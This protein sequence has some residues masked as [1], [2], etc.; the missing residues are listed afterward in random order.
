MLENYKKHY[1]E[2]LK[3]KSVVMTPYFNSSNLK[4]QM[5][6]YIDLLL[7]LLMENDKFYLY[8]SEELLVQIAKLKMYYNDMIVLKN[9][10]ILRL[11]ALKE[12][13]KEKRIP[14]HN[15]IAL[16]EEINSLSVILEMF[17]YREAGINIEVQNY[18][19]VLKSKDLSDYDYS[20]LNKRL[21]KLLFISKGIINENNLFDD[22]K[23]NVAFLE[24]ECEI[25]A[26]KHKEEAL[27]IK[28]S[29][30]L[31]DEGKILLFY[32]YGKDIFDYDFI[33]KFYLF[34]FN[35]LVD[36]INNSSFDS[37]IKED[38]YGFSF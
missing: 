8:A 12:I 13:K 21:N 5:N 6:M 16:D 10:I 22:I 33:K 7:R 32:E 34:K 3:S 4:D 18:Y 20:L 1:F 31:E 28:E 11:V 36:D 25:Y 14:R 23:L 15:K 2:L 17:L 19:D 29:F 26:Y 37:P 27:K 30:K 38:D 24:K 35:R 9:D